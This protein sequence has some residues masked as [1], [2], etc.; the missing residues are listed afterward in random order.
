MAKVS[1]SRVIHAPQHEVWGVL[2]DIA[3]ATRWNRAWTGIELTTTQTHGAGTGFRARTQDGQTFE[4]QVCEWVVPE[5]IAF[6]PIREP[7]ERY[8]ITLMSHAFDLRPAVDDATEVTLSA[9]AKA[10]GVRGRIYAMFFWAGHQR[11]GLEAALDSVQSV[12]EPEAV[13]GAH[14]E[15]EPLPE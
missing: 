15:P 1:A 2:S 7:H 13:A 9:N 11:E 6:C 12:F 4:F 8:S 14:D 10:S 3:R 5:R